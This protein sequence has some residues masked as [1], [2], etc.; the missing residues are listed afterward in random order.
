[1]ER[2]SGGGEY[3]P[4]V[5]IDHD[6][7]CESFY[8]L[9]GDRMHEYI[10]Q[11]RSRQQELQRPIFG[12]FQI[13]LQK[14]IP[15]SVDHQTYGG[16]RF[17]SSAESGILLGLSMLEHI[18][19][20]LGIDV[21]YFYDQ[22]E[23]GGVMT[24]PAINHDSFRYAMKG[25][26]QGAIAQGFVIAGGRHIEQLP[27]AYGQFVQ[28]AEDDCRDVDM[29]SEVFQAGFG[30]VMG[31]GYST[32]RYL[33][34]RAGMGEVDFDKLLDTL[35]DEDPSHR[36]TAHRLLAMLDGNIEDD[37]VPAEEI[38]GCIVQENSQYGTEIY[39]TLHALS[40]AAY[41]TSGDYEMNE[42]SEAFFM[43]ANLGV[44]A[45][46]DASGGFSRRPVYLSRWSALQLHAELANEGP[47]FQ[48]S[49]RPRVLEALRSAA[50]PSDSL[51]EYD[52]LLARITTQQSYDSD[53]W[54]AFQDGFRYAMAT[55][56]AQVELQ[57]KAEIRQLVRRE[58]MQLSDELESFLEAEDLTGSLQELDR[59]YQDHC[60]ALSITDPRAMT[61]EQ[62][63]IVLGLLLTDHDRLVPGISCIAL[64]GPSVF[65]G[66][67]DSE[68]VTDRFSL[69]TDQVLQGSISGEPTL[70]LMPT[71]INRDSRDGM[72][73][74]RLSDHRLMPS[75]I[76][77]GAELIDPDG[78]R[79]RLGD[80]VMVGLSVPG[81]RYRRIDK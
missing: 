24:M 16:A 36:Y 8:Q 70:A 10:Q 4:L 15:A 61:D 45:A 33:Y 19:Q 26:V 72:Y 9:S 11:E 65:F 21:D 78:S 71:V 62:A 17:Q 49:T 27:D 66:L 31:S 23:S 76:L 20:S 1:M 2:V 68:G 25:D 32:L 18:S 80:F 5:E 50:L 53:E 75:Y 3:D 58:A 39:E 79:K 47:D 13:V 29:S 38:L 42:R 37:R 43:G 64:D 34:E 57:R 22:W 81:T 40:L 12:A 51:N 6:A 52:E 73:D 46:V 56:V 28:D 14:L 59:A 30:N 7:M 48:E 54:G 77:Q 63:Q 67:P 60:A 35:T 55:V 74:S 69:S 41:G 44:Y